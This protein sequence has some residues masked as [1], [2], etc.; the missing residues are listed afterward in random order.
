MRSDWAA[1]AVGD[2]TDAAARD[3]IAGTPT[4][5]EFGITGTKV[6]RDAAGSGLPADFTRYCEFAVSGTASSWVSKFNL[7][8]PSNG[9]ARWWRAYVKWHVPDNLGPGGIPH[10]E[11]FG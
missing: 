2:T 9:G 11:P 8:L 7:A 4:W 1:Q 3:T 5:D 6:I 10:N